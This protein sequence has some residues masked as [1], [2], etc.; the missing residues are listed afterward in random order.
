MTR[1]KKDGASEIISILVVVESFMLENGEVQASR[2][3][4]LKII[5]IF[6]QTILIINTKII[7]MLRWPY[8]TFDLHNLK[9]VK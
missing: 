9:S 2:W 1:R 4:A 8:V 3:V 7:L 5:I 6:G